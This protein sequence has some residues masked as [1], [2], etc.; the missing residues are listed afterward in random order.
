MADD[1]VTLL[2]V[3]VVGA[4][5]LANGGAVNCLVELEGGGVRLGLGG[6]HAA[7]HVR[8]ETGVEGLQN[9]AVVGG[10]NVG[11]I[12][13]G[14]DGQVLAGDRVSLGDGLEDESLVRHYEVIMMWREVEVEV[15]DIGFGI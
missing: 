2:V 14:L 13:S 5:D 10:S 7:T 6:A 9:D 4:H 15:E 12:G 3:G 1:E 8:I 11:V